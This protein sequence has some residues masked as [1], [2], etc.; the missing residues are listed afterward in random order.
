[1]FVRKVGILGGTFDPIHHGHLIIAD[2]VLASLSLDEVRFMPNALPPHKA[3]AATTKEDRL[4]MIE[5]AIQN[6]P[7]FRVETI[8][9]MR[10]GKS[11]TYDTMVLL[12]EREPDSEFYFIIGADMID[13][14]PNWY[15]IDDLLSLVKF[16]GVNR[17][18]YAGETSYPIIHVEIP[19][20]DLSS[21]LIREKIKNGESIRYLVPDAVIQYIKEHRL[22]ET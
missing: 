15:R 3:R 12:T 19:M 17:P 18:G 7:G 8:E 1:M 11:Y 14:L 2:Q 4:K 21:S 16:V 9:L 5:L 13:Y 6:H 20:I 22:Y 10:K